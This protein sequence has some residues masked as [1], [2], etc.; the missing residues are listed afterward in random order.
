M[1]LSRRRPPEEAPDG[2]TAAPD[3]PAAAPPPG[4]RAPIPAPARDAPPVA[5]K[6]AAAAGAASADGSAG[7]GGSA[8]A[9]GS[10]SLAAAVLVKDELEPRIRR[11]SDLLRCLSACI[12][13]VLLV[14]IGLLGKAA[15]RGVET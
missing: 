4:P 9:N 11:P 2:P 14:G 13:I 8:G 5:R 3:G 10:A 15:A 12:E 1:R 6:S 7:A